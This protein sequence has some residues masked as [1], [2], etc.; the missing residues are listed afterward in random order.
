MRAIWPATALLLA[1]VI[2]ALSA[3]SDDPAEEAS[4]DDAVQET[5]SAPLVAVETVHYE[6]IPEKRR[7]SGRLGPLAQRSARSPHRGTIV[8]LEVREGEW[9]ERGQTL[10]RIAGP[11]A[12]QRQAVHAER[13]RYLRQELER[14]ERLAEADA[15]GPAEVNEARLKLLEAEQQKADLDAEISGEVIVAPA[16][17]RVIELLAAN[18]VHVE[19]GDP[20]V[21]IDDDDNLGVQIVV[22]ASETELFEDRDR[23]VVIDEGEELSVGDVTYSDYP[24]PGFV[25]VQI[26][27]EG[28]ENDRRRQVEV[29]YERSDQ[30]LLVPWT[31]VASDDE[32]WV[33]V[34]D[35]ETG[36]VS[37]RAVQ[38]GRAHQ[39]GIEVL[40]GL[41]EG[42][43]I[44][45]YEPRNHAE[46]DRVQARPVDSVGAPQGDR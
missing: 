16:S 6:E 42:E 21:L 15:A 12:G 45:R 3:C 35:A 44:L 27:L 24:H 14:W 34:V 43:Q 46:G 38:L 4:D 31:A 36:E 19:G 40:G 33:A 8:G 23:F 11:A 13:V 18:G 28:V 7:W 26:Q 39:A 2:L 41:D 32:Q 22:A 29:R 9:V 20:L 1:V 25:T 37:R 17:G 10:A 5:R 30:A